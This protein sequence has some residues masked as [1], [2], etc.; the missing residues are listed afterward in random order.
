MPGVYAPDGSLL[1]TQSD[2]SGLFNRNGS[3]NVSFLNNPLAFVTADFDK[4]GT[5]YDLV[6]SDPIDAAVLV[7]GDLVGTHTNDKSLVHLELFDQGSGLASGPAR[8]GYTLSVSAFKPGFPAL[9]AIDGEID[10]TL[11]TFRQVNGDACNILGNGTIV[12]GF[13]AF[14]EFDARS[15]DSTT[16]FAIKHN[17]HGH[18]GVINDRD[19]AYYGYNV[20][21][22]V[23]LAVTN[24]TAFRSATTV[25]A[26]W[27]NHLHFLH[28]N[29]DQLKF[30]LADAS[31]ILY[32]F[33]SPANYV[34]QLIES[35]VLTFR[36]SADA[37]VNPAFAA[38]VDF[39]P[40]VDST[41]GALTSYTSAGRYTAKGKSIEVSYVVTITNNTGGSAVL[42]FTLPVAANVTGA[43]LGK[44]FSGRNMTSG[45]GLTGR[46]V[47]ANANIMQLTISATNLYPVVTGDVVRISGTYEAA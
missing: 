20:Q 1:V 23:G 9:S 25:G 36:N 40:T 15:I 45:I 2:G 32:Q 38:P 21:K 29:N 4:T 44:I 28:E 14:A 41:G 8:A 37:I 35:G 27:Q 47:S 11:L 17:I 34:K 24:S 6:G 33:G 5:V 42:Q 31:L 19:N 39:T 43:A 3:Y 46:L 12:N 10:T 18:I 30:Q 22:I 16:P 13:G 26:A 7:R